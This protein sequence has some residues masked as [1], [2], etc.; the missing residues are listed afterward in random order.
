MV[1]ALVYCNL[2][3]RS[4]ESFAVAFL[5]WFACCW[6]LAVLVLAFMALLCVWPVFTLLLAHLEGSP[7]GMWVVSA[8]SWLLPVLVLL[9]AL[10]CWWRFRDG[11]GKDT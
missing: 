10:G 5:Y 8:V 4:P 6:L 1:A 3:H 11:S 7:R 9:F 2:R